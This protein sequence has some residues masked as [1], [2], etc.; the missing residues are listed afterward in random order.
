[1]SVLNRLAQLYDVSTLPRFMRKSALLSTSTHFIL[2][3]HPPLGVTWGGGGCPLYFFYLRIVFWTTELKRGKIIN[4][5][6]GGEKVC[7]VCVCVMCVCVCV[8]CVC[9]WCVCVWCV[10][11][12]VCVMCVCVVSVCGV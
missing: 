12:C 11:V 1:M 10:Y 7:G 9:V 2:L 8:M 4:W 5:V 6:E 3:A